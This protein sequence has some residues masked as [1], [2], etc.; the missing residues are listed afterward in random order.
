M[1]QH[2]NSKD[3]VELCKREYN[4]MKDLSHENIR[5]Y[6]IFP[7]LEKLGYPVQDSSKVHQEQEKVKGS[8]ET[9]DMSID[10]TINQVML[11]E[12]KNGNIILDENCISQLSNYITGKG[13]EWGI[14]SNG[15]HFILINNHITNGSVMD[16]I[17]FD[18]DIFNPRECKYIKYLTYDYI[19]NNKKTRYFLE[20]ARF[21]ANNGWGQP[22]KS[23]SWK[24]YKSALFS[25]FE[26]I[27]DKKK[28]HSS[29][30]DISYE[31]FEGFC[32]NIYKNKTV[33][34][35]TIEAKFRYISAMLNSKGFRTV[36][37]EFEKEL[38]MNI[39]IIR[40]GKEFILS[41]DMVKRAINVLDSN[42][43]NKR[44]VLFF[45]INIYTGRSRSEINNLQWR[46]IDFAKNTL[47][48]GGKDF[49]LPSEIKRL[50]KDIKIIVSKNNKKKSVDHIYIF[51]RSDIDGVRIKDSS[52][53]DVYYVV[54]K[55]CDWKNCCPEKIAVALIP[56]LY[57][58]G[59]SIE[60]IAC[61]T[62]KKLSNIENLIPY[63]DMIQQVNL[64]KGHA[65]RVH[66]YTDILG[67]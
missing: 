9:Y 49:V 51:T 12:V 66:P 53:N 59:Y 37:F 34:I 18:I 8:R 38:N 19:Y 29:L 60:E 47:N 25:F 1:K 31:N 28:R 13:G 65:K 40:T 22:E 20:I 62:G 24:Q 14:L 45:L 41:D 16:K 63:E 57:K 23:S 30:D 52:I 33:S 56:Q 6:I 32:E 39:D 15:H 46:N 43:N 5:H 44:N 2:E 64:N 21:K 48:I 50:L 27:D 42:K 7:V 35:K 11:I 17:V 58:N 61:L 36:P 67:L 4:Q 26:Y 55:Q 10:C 3:I 54:Q